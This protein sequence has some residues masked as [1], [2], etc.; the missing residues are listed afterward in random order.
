MQSTPYKR[1]HASPPPSPSDD[2][3]TLDIDAAKRPRT[4]GPS[5]SE[6]MDAADSLLKIS[7]TDAQTRPGARSL[8][9]AMRS[10]SFNAENDGECKNM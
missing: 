8:T 7:S 10:L 4:A 3:W 6:V 2:Q 1:T 5:H 9:K